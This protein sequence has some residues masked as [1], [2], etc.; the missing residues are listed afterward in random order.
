M[1]QFAS[2]CRAIRAFSASLPDRHAA[3]YAGSL[4]CVINIPPALR[5]D[6][7]RPVCHHV[8][9]YKGATRSSGGVKVRFREGTRSEPFSKKKK[10]MKKSL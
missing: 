10:I 8:Y 7:E 1:V 5:W 4:S 6:V 2:R 9:G 3:R